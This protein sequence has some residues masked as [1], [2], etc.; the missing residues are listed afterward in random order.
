MKRNGFLEFLAGERSLVFQAIQA[1]LFVVY[2]VISV[3]LSYGVNDLYFAIVVGG[4]IVYAFCIIIEI[5]RFW[6]RHR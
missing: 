6:R 1:I 2:L 3:R 5:V 4:S